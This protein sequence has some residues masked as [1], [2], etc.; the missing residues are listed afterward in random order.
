MPAETHQLR[1]SV[2]VDD[3]VA[4]LAAVL[5]ASAPDPGPLTLVELGVDDDLA[6]VHLW[7]AVVEELGERATGELEFDERPLTLRHLAEAF[8]RCLQ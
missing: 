1:E 2:G 3:V 7:K 8:H 4:L 5:D 6:L